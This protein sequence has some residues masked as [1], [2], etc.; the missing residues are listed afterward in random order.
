MTRDEPGAVAFQTSSISTA[1]VPSVA[2]PRTGTVAM[3]MRSLDEARDAMGGEKCSS[4][5]AACARNV[6]IATATKTAY[7]VGERICD[8]LRQPNDIEFS[9]ERSESAASTG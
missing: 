1:T 9:G 5:I 3:T 6:T 4:G 8:H 2:A 7:R